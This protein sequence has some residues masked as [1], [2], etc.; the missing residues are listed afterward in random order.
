MESWPAWRGIRSI[1]RLAADFTPQL[2]E[3]ACERALAL[4][5][6]SYRAV[7]TLIETPPVPASS[8]ALDLAHDNVRGP[9]YFQ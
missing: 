5:S 8:P 9:E 3:C 4:Q 6:Y 2:L 1:L 7:R